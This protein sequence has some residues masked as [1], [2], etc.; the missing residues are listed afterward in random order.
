[1]F[2]NYIRVPHVSP[3]P[4]KIDALARA[5]HWPTGLIG[6]G[7]IAIGELGGGSIKSDLEQFCKMV[8]MPVPTV[9]DHS[10][11]GGR[12]NGDP[13]DP[14]SGEV[15]L[16]IQAAAASYW[17]AT[18]KPAEIHVYYAPNG[19]N[20]LVAATLQAAADSMDVFS[21]SWGANEAQTGRT[22]CMAME[23]A[24]LQTLHSA[25]MI[26]LA[27]SGD[28]GSRDLLPGTHVDSPASCPHVLACGGTKKT[29]P[30]FLA[31]TET[32]WIDGGGGFSTV[33]DMPRWTSGAPHG[34]RMVPDWA[35]N[36]DPST[37]VKVMLN[38][39]VQV[40]G[41]TSFCAPF[42]AGLIAACG[43][44]RGLLTPDG[45]GPLLW[46][47]HMVFDDITKGSN[48]MFRAKVGPDACTG[49]GVPH[50]ANIAALLTA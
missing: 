30:I 50:G 43:K 44:K 42:L 31:S 46:A 49:L 39:Q 21:W 34:G 19:G 7:K 20:S 9:V 10:V 25:G 47:H 41:G 17:V 2:R 12:N 6:G 40:F 22:G 33:F 11:N 13:T 38:G 24:T 18:R 8:G 35:T 48:G 45:I 27:A 37:G 26:T 16:D 1:M 29:S 5:Y 23:A 28:D 3:S 4:W 36:A 15:A 14:A 32:A